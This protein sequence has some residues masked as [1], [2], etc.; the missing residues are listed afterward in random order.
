MA[1]FPWE[2][3]V[4]FNGIEFSSARLP[5]SYL[6]AL[7]SLQFTEPTLILFGF[8]LIGMV[9]LFV[10][11]PSHRPLLC[12]VLGWIILPLLWVIIFQPVMYDNFRQFLFL[13]P[14][15]FIFVGIGLETVRRENSKQV[16]G[17]VAHGI[18]LCPGILGLFSLHPYQYLYY[19]QLTGG[20]QG[21]FRR[22]EMDYWMTSYRQT[23]YFLNEVTK[24][25]SRVAV[26]KNPGLFQLFSK[27]GIEVKENDQTCDFD[28]AVITTRH[29]LD[30]RT[31]PEE[32]VSTASAKEKRY[33]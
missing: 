3:T 10:K 32:P 5:R 2:G 11:K 31:Y 14:A 28:Y 24:S 23:A 18:D 19:N 12:L 20:V 13:I 33:S 15:L 9:V 7:L 1:N 25:G 22:Y 26:I 29:S 16:I 17:H 4:L 30:L 27:P 21:A 8:G 6:P